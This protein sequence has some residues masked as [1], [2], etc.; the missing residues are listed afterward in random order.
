MFAHRG[1]TPLSSNEY[2]SF[3]VQDTISTGNFTINAGFRYDLQEG[4]N[5]P[6]TIDGNPAFPDL[7]PA[8]NF[9]GEAAPFDWET[10][11]PRIGVTYA[12][13]EERKTLIR[14][15]FAQFPE[16]LQSGNI[17]RLNPLADAY[18]YY[19]FTDSNGDGIWQ[20]SEPLTDSKR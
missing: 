16:Q 6:F 20:A 3:W 19:G 18:A 7:M 4:S 8:L 5:E 13:G 14:G 9:S 1:E 10:I 15:S 12:L 17:D 2:T 11:S